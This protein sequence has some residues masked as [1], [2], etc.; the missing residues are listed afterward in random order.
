MST[1]AGVLGVL[2]GMVT[3]FVAAVTVGAWALYFSEEHGGDVPL[4]APILLSSGTLGM[5]G[6]VVALVRI[7]RRGVKSS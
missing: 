3:V 4:V 1:I 2:L 6:L 5:S 7:G